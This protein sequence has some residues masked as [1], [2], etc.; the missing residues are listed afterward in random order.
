MDRIMPSIK[1]K[2]KNIPKNNI[3]SKLNIK[4]KNG[5]LSSDISK[6]F[7]AKKENN[8]NNE[9]DNGYKYFLTMR[10]LVFN[11]NATLKYMSLCIS[12]PLQFLLL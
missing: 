9:I 1:N 2:T 3:N 5:L 8:I 7:N 10:E 12:D 4:F 11:C 6:K